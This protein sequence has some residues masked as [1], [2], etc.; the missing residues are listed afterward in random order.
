[1]R[2]EMRPITDPSWLDFLSKRE[3]AVIFHHPAWAGMLAEC[4]GYRP[5]VL[6]SLDD[7]ER[8]N[9]GIPF[10]DVRSRLTGHRWV[11]LPFSDSCAPLCSNEAVL[12]SLVGHL[13]ARYEERAIPRMEIRSP[14]PG[15]PPV[16]RDDRFVRHTIRLAN[17]PD[18][19]YRAFDRT[20]IQQPLR[21]AVKRGVEIR[22]GTGKSDMFIFYRMLVDTRRR[23]GAPAQ[24]KRFFDLL[25]DRIMAKDLGFL[26]LAYKGTEP[27]GGAVFAHYGSTLTGKYGASEPAHWNL[28]PN[29]L[30]LWTAITWGCERGLTCFDFGR[31]ETANGN[32]RAYK[33]GWGAV[34]E[35]LAYSTIADRAPKHGSGRLGA[36][37]K[38]V[39]R[40]SPPAVCR[41]VGEAFYKH[42]A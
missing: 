22:R 11:S 31:T 6:A 13:C 8:V 29:N 18:T 33:N 21:Q 17:D 24:P 38:F 32:L 4:Y 12:Q 19:L 37:M 15:G 41:L 2:I 3:N 9:G 40:N 1:M 30:L 25:W 16:H 10:M 14:V 26:L 5:F 20:R 7:G 42:Y 35:P 27:I 34:E 39:I 28:R 23:L 36:L